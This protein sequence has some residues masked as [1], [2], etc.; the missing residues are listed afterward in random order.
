VK[1]SH[2]LSQ[3]GQQADENI[4]VYRHPLLEIEMSLP[5]PARLSARAPASLRIKPLASSHPR[6]ISRM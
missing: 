3:I 5:V 1:R 2:P 6:R 4:H